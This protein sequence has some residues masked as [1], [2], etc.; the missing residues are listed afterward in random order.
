MPLVQRARRRLV[1]IL[2][3]HGGLPPGDTTRRPFL[4]LLSF[5]ALVPQERW[6]ETKIDD[7]DGPKYKDRLFD[8]N[9]LR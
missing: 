2:P 7:L 8:W 6:G 3:R 9:Q 5:H 1:P 4:D